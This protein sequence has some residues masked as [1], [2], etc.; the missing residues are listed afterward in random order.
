MYQFMALL[1]LLLGTACANIIGE[2]PGQGQTSYEATQPDAV[3]QIYDDEELRKKLITLRKQD[4][5]DQAE[6]IRKADPK[7]KAKPVAKTMIP[8]A[9][10]QSMA[11]KPI[12]QAPAISP[13]ATQSI[14]VVKTLP[15]TEKIQEQLWVRVSFRS[16]HTAVNKKMLKAL[17]SIA[18]KYLAEPRTQTLVVRGFCDGEPIGGYTSRKHKSRHGFTSQL[19]LSQSR[20]RAVADVLIKA[21]IKENVIRVEGYGAKHFIADNESKAG[22]DRNRRVDVFLIGS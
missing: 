22:R 2:D 20:A 5:L 17:T 8:P 15:A 19:A 9:K 3:G 6:R 1:L 16:G 14:D 21:G 11:L 18:G 13:V 4:Q 10:P 7:Y 12:E